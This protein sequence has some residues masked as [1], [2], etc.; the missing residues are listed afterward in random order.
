M[1]A[2]IEDRYDLGV[3]KVICI[4]TSCSM[5]NFKIYHN[6]SI[7]PSYLNWDAGRWINKTCIPI[8]DHL[9]CDRNVWYGS[10]KVKYMNKGK[11]QKSSLPLKDS[12]FKQ[13]VFF[14]HKIFGF[15]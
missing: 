8:I 11:N 15:S 14:V 6:I 1:V 4:W 3:W 5:G 10:L 7:F 12:H 2:I 9:W 13:A